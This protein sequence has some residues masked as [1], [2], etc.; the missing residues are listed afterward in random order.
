MATPVPLPIVM[1][2]RKDLDTLATKDDHELNGAEWIVYDALGACLQ[3]L[4]ARR[5]DLDR[6]GDADLRGACPTSRCC[7]QSASHAI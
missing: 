6:G 7:S 2:S 3:R 5:P 4:R 1:R